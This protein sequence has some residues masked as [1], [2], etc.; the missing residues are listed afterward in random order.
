MKKPPALQEPMD[1]PN[2]DFPIKVNLSKAKGYGRLMFP[3]HWHKH[4]EIL[5]VQS[6]ALAV[7]CNSE[8]FTAHEGDLVIIGSHDLHSGFSHSDDLAY[9]VMIL[10]PALLHSASLDAAQTKFITPI[11]RNQIVF[12][13]K[14]SGDADVSECMYA[15]IQEMGERQLG[16]ELSV[17]SQ[18]FRM[19]TLL[20]RR[21]VKAHLPQSNY[22]QRRHN[23]ERFQPVLSY[24]ES[25][26]DEE[27][28]VAQLSELAG[29][30]RFHFSRIFKELTDRTVTEYVIDIRLREAEYLL[31]NTD[32]TISEIALA[33]GFSDIYYFSR[34]FK[35]AKHR[36]PSEVR[37][38]LRT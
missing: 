19:L 32:M 28:S 5:F 36:S 2:P 18:L 34:T 27:L 37:K 14:L 21:H 24:I 31:H 26:Y 7:E 25:H 20:M 30:S 1:M 38:R 15:I 23:L 12:H 3:T 35:K 22:E 9:Y 33:V 6:G 11:V 29:L 10:D 4:M 13:H 8:R 16:Y 17:K